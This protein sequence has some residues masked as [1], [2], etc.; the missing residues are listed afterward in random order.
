[1][2]VTINN[3][4]TNE[5]IEVELSLTT[6]L[7]TQPDGLQELQVSGN[8]IANLTGDHTHGL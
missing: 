4:L 1:M 6:V 3:P 8:G 5:P 2:L 7:I